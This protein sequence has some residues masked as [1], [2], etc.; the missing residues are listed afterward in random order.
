MDWGGCYRPCVP[1]VAA[2]GE[3][4]SP[5]AALMFLLPAGPVP[6]EVAALRHRAAIAFHPGP[7]QEPDP[8]EVSP[9]RRSGP[10]L[11]VALSV[12]PLSRM[13]KGICVSID[14]ATLI[15]SAKI[16]FFPL[17]KHPLL[18]K[19]VFRYALYIGLIC[20]HRL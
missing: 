3:L 18:L 14:A 16:F 8:G 4:P 17:S 5:G 9:E 13:K 12:K 10:R 11:R 1:K 15:F 6:G 2:L 7:S 20:V 19:C